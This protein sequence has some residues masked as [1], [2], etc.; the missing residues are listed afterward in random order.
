[1]YNIVRFYNQNRRKIWVTIL[2]I[3]FI[4]VIIQLFNFGAKKQL[5]DRTENIISNA[6]NVSEYKE[7]SDS[8]VSG[9][10][11]PEIFQEEYGQLIDNFLSNCV[12]GN[13][14]Q[15]YQLLSEECKEELYPTV[16]SFSIDYCEGKFDSGKE[17]NF[18]S[19]ISDVKTIY[20]VKIYDSIL[21]SGNANMNYIEDY[22]T[23]TKEEGETKLNISNFVD[24]KSYNDISE[25]YENINIKVENISDYMD[26]EV[27][28]INIENNS[29]KKI[30]LDSKKDTDGVYVIDNKGNKNYALLNENKDEDLII[31]GNSSKKISIKFAKTYQ[32]RL[33]TNEICFSKIVLEYDMFTNDESYSNYA[34]IEIQ[35]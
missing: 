18:Q 3:I 1:M 21:H 34:S 27:V 9:G 6:N 20:Q 14:E 16:K 11:V 15:A 33:Y 7:K 24:R 2:I 4:F 10:S 28:Q 29:D 31:D 35:L 26:F 32:S 5:D 30:M 12:S 17:Y 13:Y 25:D 23:I 22:Y 19:W 8:L